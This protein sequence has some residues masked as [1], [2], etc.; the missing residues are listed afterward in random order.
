MKIAILFASFKDYWTKKKIN[1]ND[2]AKQSTKEREIWL[3]IERPKDI[4]SHTKTILPS[5][6][7]KHQRFVEYEN[8]KYLRSGFFHQ[9]P[10]ESLIVKKVLEFWKNLQKSSRRYFLHDSCIGPP[11]L[12]IKSV[13][14]RK[15]TWKWRQS[16]LRLIKFTSAHHL[17]WCQSPNQFVLRKYSLF[18][19][20]LGLSYKRISVLWTHTVMLLTKT[21]LLQEYYDFQGDDSHTLLTSCLFISL[22]KRLLF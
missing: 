9:V 2:I 10:S 4:I 14:H 19:I 12:S 22:R 1:K 8:N 6:K 11:D 21:Q 5:V 16:L 13:C 17:C 7:K 3:I 15:L 18:I 20:S